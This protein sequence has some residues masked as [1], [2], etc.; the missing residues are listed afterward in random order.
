M[1]DINLQ[2]YFTACDLGN[3]CICIRYYNRPISKSDDD[4]VGCCS[5][6]HLALEVSFLPRCFDGFVISSLS[7]LTVGRQTCYN[8]PFSKKGNTNF[9]Q[10]ILRLVVTGNSVYHLDE[11]KVI[12]VRPLQ[13]YSHSYFIFYKFNIHNKII[14]TTTTNQWWLWLK[15]KER[16]QSW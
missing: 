15:V 14:T 13:V 5:C 16:L 6:L 11:K 10:G 1:C 12:E 3:P 9:T 7:C 2:C 8:W 4:M